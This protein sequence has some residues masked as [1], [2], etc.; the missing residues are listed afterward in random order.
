MNYKN[1]E[2]FKLIDLESDEKY[3]FIKA[4]VVYKDNKYNFCTFESKTK[5]MHR[6]ISIESDV[7]YK[8]DLGGSTEKYLAIVKENQ[9]IFVKFMGRQLIKT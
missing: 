7:K 3:V 6:L 2:L 5:E 1:I 4:L 8:C 9:L